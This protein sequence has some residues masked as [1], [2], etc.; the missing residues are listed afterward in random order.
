M[1]W[2]ILL[3]NCFRNSKNIKLSCCSQALL[4]QGTIISPL[5]NREKKKCSLAYLVVVL[6]YNSLNYSVLKFCI[7]QKLI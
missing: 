6:L 2:Y 3:K 1:L 7:N 5:E 4:I